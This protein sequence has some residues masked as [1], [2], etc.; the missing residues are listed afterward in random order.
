L[1]EVFRKICARTGSNSSVVSKS[2]F[3]SLCSLLESRGVIEL[4][5]GLGGPKT[6]AV[7]KSP[8]CTTVVLRASL[9]DLRRDLCN[10]ESG[11]MFHVLLDNPGLVC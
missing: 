4:R 8:R 9:E 6:P 3:T 11:K 5:D 10:D 2:E 7:F 1:Y